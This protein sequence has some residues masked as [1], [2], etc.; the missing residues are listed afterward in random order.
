MNRTLLRDLA[1]ERAGPELHRRREA[2]VRKLAREEEEVAFL[3]E[4][5]ADEMVSQHPADIG[6]VLEMT[7]DAVGN[8]E[9]AKRELRRI[10]DALARL[11]AGRYGVCEACDGDIA[12]ERLEVL[13]YTAY[14]VTCQAKLERRHRVP[15]TL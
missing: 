10:D 11:A 7:E 1:R 3:T 14:C 4:S 15:A 13:P 6:A 8:R 12:P 2:L 9:L 5:E